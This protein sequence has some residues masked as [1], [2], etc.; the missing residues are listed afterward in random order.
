MQQSSVAGRVFLQ[1]VSRLNAFAF[2]QQLQRLYCV[3]NH[4][5]SVQRIY[6]LSQQCNGQ[7]VQRQHKYTGVTN[8]AMSKTSTRNKINIKIYLLSS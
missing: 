1:E 8:E 4:T 6:V 3:R 7:L 2:S 5:Y